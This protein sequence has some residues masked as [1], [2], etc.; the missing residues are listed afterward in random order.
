MRTRTIFTDANSIGQAEK[1]KPVPFSEK[2]LNVVHKYINFKNDMMNIQDSLDSLKRNFIKLNEISSLKASNILNQNIKSESDL[3]IE[4]NSRFDALAT[5]GVLLTSQIQEFE[6]K[7]FPTFNSKVDP[8]HKKRLSLIVEKHFDES[9]EYRLVYLLRNFTSHVGKTVKLKDGC[10]F[11]DLETILSTS[12]SQNDKIKMIFDSDTTAKKYPNLEVP[13]D[14]CVRIY[15]ENVLAALITFLDTIRLKTGTEIDREMSKL[16]F[17]YS[18]YI[19]KLNV[20]NYNSWYGSNIDPKFIG[21]VPFYAAT[22]S[23]N[24]E[25]ASLSDSMKTFLLTQVQVTLNFKKSL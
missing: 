24:I 9:A 6:K 15:V 21:K 13:I 5:S 22:D 7:Y 18:R 1:Y 2:E 8:Q 17:K 14:N 4:I 12:F 23:K 16:N 3:Y 20:N 25:F 10:A 19:I 11:F